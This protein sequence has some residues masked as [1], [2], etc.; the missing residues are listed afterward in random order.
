MSVFTA[1]VTVMY[2]QL[3]DDQWGLNGRTVT[4][5]VDSAKLVNA[6]RYNDQIVVLSADLSAQHLQW[7][8]LGAS[9]PGSLLM[10]QADHP[11]DVRT[12]SPTDVT[13]LSGVQLMY[14]AGHVSNIY[15]DT[16][17]W[18]TTTIRLIG[19]GGSAAELSTSLP[20]P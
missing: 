1:R 15:V 5:L 19:A 8:P 11:C 10:F 13:F 20:L 3:V 12:N 14:L 4:F 17:S 18:A 9:A 16:G 6:D 7:S 2:E